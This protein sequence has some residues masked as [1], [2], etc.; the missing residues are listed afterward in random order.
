MISLLLNKWYEMNF[1]LVRAV[2]MADGLGNP[3]LLPYVLRQVLGD[4]C[5]LCQF[6]WAVDVP[7]AQHDAELLCTI[8]LCAI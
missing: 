5:V 2:S 6:I 8:V 7:S 4:V 1:S 3:Q